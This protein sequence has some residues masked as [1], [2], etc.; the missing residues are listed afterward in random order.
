MGH[1]ILF[2]RTLQKSKIKIAI[3][4]PQLLE[5]LEDHNQLQTGKTPLCRP[6]FPTK[7]IGSYTRNK[8]NVWYLY[9]NYCQLLSEK[10]PVL[11]VI[12]TLLIHRICC[13]I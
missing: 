7:T 5:N 4:N 3:R 6:P 2:K 8:W 12:T 1:L 10:Y 13:L 11:L 9:E